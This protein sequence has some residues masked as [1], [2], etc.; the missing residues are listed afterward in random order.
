[1]NKGEYCLRGTKDCKK[2]F[3]YIIENDFCE[4]RNLNKLI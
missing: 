2:K 4:E 1:M 3:Y